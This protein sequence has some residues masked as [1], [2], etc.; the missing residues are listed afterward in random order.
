MKFSHKLAAFSAVLSLASLSLFSIIQFNK[1]QQVITGEVSSSINEVTSLVTDNLN[2]I[3]D[4]KVAIV[5]FTLNS[6]SVDYSPYNVENCFNNL[7]VKNNFVRAG[8]G[9]NYD[10]SLVENDPDWDP[11]QDNYDSRKQP[12][13]KL[14]QNNKGFS[15]SEPR[16][17][18]KG[19]LILSI[20]TPNYIGENKDSLLGVTFF[21]LDLDF[22]N[23]IVNKTRI[24]NGGGHIFIVSN[25][26]TII[27]HP[28]KTL[29]GKNLSAFDPD[30]TITQE[31][32]EYEINDNTYKIGFIPLDSVD[33]QIG[34]YIDQVDAYS[35]ITDMRNSSLIFMGIAF[36]LI[37]I[38][39]VLLIQV[40]MKPL[41]LLG[42]TIDDVS[43]GEADLTQ[44]LSTKTDQEFARLAHG[45]NT[46][47]ER[48]QKQMIESKEVSRQIE[49]ITHETAGNANEANT[50]M[51]EQQKELDQLVTAMH[52]LT[53]TSGEVATYAQNAAQSTDEAMQATEKGNSTVEHTAQSI[54]HLSMQIENAVEVTNKLAQ[55]T[56]EIDS[57]L[58]V[59]NGISEQTNLLALNAAI[60][61]ARAGEQGRGFAVVADEVRTLAQ[62]TQDATHEIQA[63][64][65]ELQTNAHNVVEI[66]EKSQSDVSN[67]VDAGE[68]AN[69]A[70]AAIS[71]AVTQATD[72][73]TQIASAAEQQSIVSEEVNQ[74]TVTISEF[75]DKV[76]SVMETT[77][78]KAKEQLKL[79]EHQH[80]LMDEFKL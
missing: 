57:I 56:D 41:N 36:I 7:S 24:A 53:T 80:A 12:W 39:S 60:E 6:I 15:F 64:T 25:K 46:F 26:G 18:E 10:G 20:V 76:V 42:Q 55:S 74:N 13:Y 59:I 28:D 43:T 35:D 63:M 2:Q 9:F 54:H 67:S 3:L 1:I 31:A 45:F 72:L 49:S 70:L 62:R 73:I 78:D 37:L 33:W 5:K 44:R 19:N 69:Q 14:G 58:G 48:L 23:N 30:L 75:A 17:S 65:G 40:L 4:S 66:M 16:R 68:Q 34:Y 79:V 50:S 47:I 29:I 71:Q 27:A 61:A 32:K 22:L 38:C 51:L 11:N 52:E 77:N 8:L 21:D